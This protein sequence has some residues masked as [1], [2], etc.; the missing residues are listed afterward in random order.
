MLLDPMIENLNLNGYKKPPLPTMPFKT[1]GLCGVSTDVFLCWP[2]TY[3]I[4]RLVH[5]WS[6]LHNA[7]VNLEAVSSIEVLDLSSTQE[8]ISKGLEVMQLL[9]LPVQN[10]LSNGWFKSCE[11]KVKTHWFKLYSF[12]THLRFS[13]AAQ[14]AET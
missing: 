7:D 6:K 1:L 14:Y 12:K 3:S 13:S 9:W 8:G 4:W 10:Y 2:L 11:V 5:P